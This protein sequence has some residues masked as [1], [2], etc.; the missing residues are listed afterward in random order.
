MLQ[1]CIIS[2]RK[3]KR[4]RN[5][6]FDLGSHSFAEFKGVISSSLTKGARS[7]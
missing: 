5:T 6:A 4:I 7:N 1:L 2:L 3:N